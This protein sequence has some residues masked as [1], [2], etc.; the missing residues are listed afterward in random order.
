MIGA[1]VPFF[2]QNRAPIKEKT[3][4]AKVGANVQKRVPKKVPKSGSKS[5]PKRAYNWIK[6]K[7]MRVDQTH[8]VSEQ[9][10]K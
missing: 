10:A 6:K 4:S 2:A 5:G 9:V 1:D 8:F 3:G 7:H